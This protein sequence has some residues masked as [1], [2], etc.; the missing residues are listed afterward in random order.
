ML[1]AGLVG[2]PNVGKSTLFNALLSKQVAEAANYPFCTIDPN[3]GVVE[4]PDERLPVLAEIAKSEK[5]VPAAIEFV[6]IAGLVQGAHQGEG[7]GNKFLSHIREVDAI[8]FVL[9][10]FTDDNIARAGSTTPDQDLKILQTELQ[11][12]DLQTLEKQKEPRGNATK[13]ELIRWSAVQKVR[14]QLEQANN[15]STVALSEDEQKEIKSFSLLTQKPFIIVLNSD[16]ETVKQSTVIGEYETISLC[17]K[18]EEQL[19][20]LSGEEKKELLEAYGFSEPGLNK[21]IK[22]AYRT[23]GLLTFLTAG[24]KEVRAWPVPQGTLAPQ[25]AGTIHTDFEKAFIKAK[26]VTYTDFVSGKGWIGAR[27]AGKIRM[28]GKEYC[29]QEG[30]VVEFIVNA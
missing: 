6:D 10:N 14:S 15:A 24:E 1:Q 19:G 12:A 22:T 29:I 26:V 13:E 3:I 16:E 18:L 17:A 21:L 8:I 30:D 2:L 20:G 25:A 5:I 23:L 4:V 7:L 28:E 27:E 11:L 9:R